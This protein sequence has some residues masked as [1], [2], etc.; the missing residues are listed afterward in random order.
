MNHA[1][2][3][4][5]IS[6]YKSN[7]R[8]L[9]W[10]ETSDPYR[11]WLS[12]IILQQTRVEQGL[13]YFHRF[14]EIFPSLKDLAEAPDEKVMKCW[15][16]LG[17]Y[18]RARNLQS[19]ARHVFYECQGNFPEKYHDLLKLKGVGPYTA[20]AIASFSFGEKIPVVDGNVYRFISR[21]FGIDL[22]VG[23]QKAHRYFSE[24]LLKLMP[25][26]RPDLFNQALMEF[27]GLQCVP[28]SPK[29]VRCPFRENCYARRNNSVSAF[30]VKG[31][32]TK[33]KEV[34][35]NFG[36][37]HHQGKF[38]L[39]QRDDQGIWKRLWHFPLI[40]T[41]RAMEIPEILSLFAKDWNIS[42]NELR[43]T[44]VWKTIHLLSHRK[45]HA[46][47]WELE[48][49]IPPNKNDIFE[50]EADEIEKYALPRLMTKY[51]IERKHVSK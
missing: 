4:T 32:K 27:G 12:E 49:D 34:Y 33:V 17:Y 3:E 41:N 16:G 42:L 14:M 31:R 46:F 29:C 26:D 44:G 43:Q 15:Q 25:D 6:W 2:S 11:I 24:L 48:A 36:V 38:Y 22:E 7:A 47:F 30:P 5:L 39:N 19:A 10:R 20:A 50:M 35:F 1:F 28:Q 45:I 21:Y 23:N 18:S 8:N 51:L 13:P 9:P 37:V 40:E